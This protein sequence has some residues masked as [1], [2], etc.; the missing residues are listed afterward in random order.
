MKLQSH[1]V[2]LCTVRSESTRAP[3]KAGGNAAWPKPP[4]WDRP[5]RQLSL[6]KTGRF[7]EEQPVS[8][9]HQPVGHVM[10]GVGDAPR[11]V[12][13]GVDGDDKSCECC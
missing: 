12:V 13:G 7:A 1:V 6:R 10:L 8:L 3:G 9:F 5:G 2:G 11:E 4:H